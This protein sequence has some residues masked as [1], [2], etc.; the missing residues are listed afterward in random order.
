LEFVTRLPLDAP[1]VKQAL[2]E[3]WSACEPL[4]TVPLAETEALVQSRYS[5]AEWNLRLQGLMNE[6]T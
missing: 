3:A 1:A 5:R 4:E 6:A 2:R